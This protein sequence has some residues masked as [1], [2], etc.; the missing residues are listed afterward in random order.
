LSINIAI[1]SVAMP[2]AASVPTWTAFVAVYSAAR[3][4]LAGEWSVGAPLVAETWPAK[5]RGLVLG[6]NRSGFSL[7]TALAGLLTAFIAADYGWRAAFYI[8]GLVAILAI[9]IRLFVPESPE[10]VRSKGR[11]ERIKKALVDRI[12][13]SAEDK[14]WWRKAKQPG[15]AQLFLP[16]TRRATILVTVVFT[17]LL[18]SFT[19]MTYFMPLY[20]SETHGW[21]T[22]EYGIFI[23]WWGLVGI[24]AYWISGGLSDKIGRRLVFVICLTWA[25]FF[26]AIWSFTTNHALLWILGLIW[27]FGY[28]GVYGPLASFLS[29]LYP[30]RIRATGTGFT[31]ACA[32]LIASI[33]WPYVL[34]YL[35]Q[36]TGSFSTCFLLTSG[37]LI[38]VAVIVW[39]FSP[40]SAQRELNSIGE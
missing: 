3:F 30:T 38:L 40:E 6:A 26:I 1:F 16:D 24:P 15:L 23:T 22:Q 32:S 8:P 27:S 10:W 29:E 2:I 33:L 20:L 36:W 13:L 19:T 35:R 18:M 9:Y 4:S 21:T 17:G 31:I 7:G 39:F 28:A 14:N 5:Y 25:G 11:K 34:V 12:P 37:A